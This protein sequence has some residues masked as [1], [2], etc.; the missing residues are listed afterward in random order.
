LPK[1]SESADVLYFQ[2]DLRPVLYAFRYFPGPMDKGIGSNVGMR[3]PK[4]SGR[5][6]GLEVQS[7]ALLH[8]VVPKVLAELKRLSDSMGELAFA[9]TENG[10]GTVFSTTPGITAFETVVQA[11]PLFPLWTFAGR[12]QGPTI[13]NL[14]Q[15]Q[16]Q[17][18]LALSGLVVCCLVLAIGMSFRAVAREAKLA[19]LKSGFVSNVSH[20]M[21]TSKTSPR[22][23]GSHWA[24]RFAVSLFLIA[25]SMKR[26]KMYFP[27]KPIVASGDEQPR[28]SARTPD[29]ADAR[30]IDVASF[31]SMMFS[32]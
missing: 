12:H 28:Q 20:P 9:V 25:R 10:L 19:E 4:D 29:V 7:D 32:R 8:E 21:P 15:E 22:A 26:G 27:Y 11:G 17:R 2:S 6:A 3:S 31:K 13:E 5:W 16:F 24:R 23:W 18:G 1:D 14:A 30:C